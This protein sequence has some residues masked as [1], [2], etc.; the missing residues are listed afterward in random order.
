[1]EGSE[2]I[3]AI[4]L[5]LGGVAV[6]LSRPQVADPGPPVALD[7]PAAFPVSGGVHDADNDDATEDRD[8]KAGED[9]ADHD[10]DDQFDVAQPTPVKADSD[11][12]EDD[13]PYDVEDD[14]DADDARD[15]DD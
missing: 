14:G 13:D 15:T 8:A 11:D 9:D 1:M 6:A 7:S 2:L 3:L 12:W 4:L 5:A 10:S